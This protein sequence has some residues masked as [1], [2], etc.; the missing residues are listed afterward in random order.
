MDATNKSWHD[1][2]KKR[3]LPGLS[4]ESTCT[5]I[6]IKRRTTADAHAARCSVETQEIKFRFA[7]I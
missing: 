4:G 2:Q 6:R 5:G 7:K 1:E 3:S